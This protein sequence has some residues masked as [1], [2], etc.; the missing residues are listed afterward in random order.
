V[1]SDYDTL[2]CQEKGTLKRST[3]KTRNGGNSLK[4]MTLKKK[5]VQRFRNEG[6][7]SNSLEM[8]LQ[9]FG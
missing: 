9:G 3:K 7:P 1:V 8:L 5:I 2:V 4:K 6:V